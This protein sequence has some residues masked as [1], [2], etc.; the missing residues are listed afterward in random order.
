VSDNTAILT[1]PAAVGVF[2]NATPFANSRAWSASSSVDSNA[3]S[4][5][6]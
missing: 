5:M 4:V 6:P 2:V 1:G 3:A